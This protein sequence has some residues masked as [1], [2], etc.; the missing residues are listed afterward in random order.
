MYAQAQKH[1]RTP[2]AE[3][4]FWCGWTLLLTN[5]TEKLVE[6]EGVGDQQLIIHSPGSA[7]L[8]SSGSLGLLP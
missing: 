6:L 1:G 3:S 5:C 8:R 2:S 4:F 7:I